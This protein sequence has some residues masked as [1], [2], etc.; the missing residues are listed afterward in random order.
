MKERG[1]LAVVIQKRR[2]KP[3]VSPKKIGLDC[4]QVLVYQSYH[5][6]KVFSISETKI[7]QYKKLLAVCENAPFLGTVLTEILSNKNSSKCKMK[8]EMTFAG[9]E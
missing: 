4:C 1:L 3:F 5:R 6:R 7:D 9:F 2:R 8:T